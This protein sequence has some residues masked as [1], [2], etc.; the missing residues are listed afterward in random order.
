MCQ[1]VAHLL[2]RG[3]LGM[4]RP[5]QPRTGATRIQGREI[6]TAT[7]T[8][9][10]R[11]SIRRSR[12]LPFAAAGLAVLFLAPALA[13]ADASG[14]DAASATAVATVVPMAVEDEIDALGQSTFPS[15]YGDIAIVNDRTQI[16]VYLTTPTPAIE[17]AFEA[18]APAGMLVFHSTP[19]SLQ[20]LHAL[21]QTVEDQWTQLRDQGIN[22][23]EFGPNI[24][25]G[26]EDVGVENLTDADTEALDSLFGA[27]ALNVY[28][29]TPED[30]NS[31]QV[32]VSRN[33]DVAPYNG[34]D[35]IAHE[36]STAKYLCTSGFGIRISGNPRLLT[37]GHCY[38]VGD[39]VINERCTSFTDCTGGMAAM[40]NVTQ[41]G[42]GDNR[43]N[44]NGQ[45]LD[46]AVFTG[47]NGNGTCGGSDL[48]FTGDLGNPQIATVAGV[49]AWHV[50][51]QVC[52]SGAYG[53]EKCGFEVRQIDYCDTIGKYY[54]CHLTRTLNNNDN[55]VEGDSGAPV[56]LF[57]GSSLYAV[58][59]HTGHDD[60]HH[61]WFTG[62]NRILD[63]WNACLITGS[64]CTT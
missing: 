32:D 48:I 25:I 30:V 46:S 40:G 20:T 52:E 9:L 19:R 15:V 42:L 7:A 26:K 22:V 4:P 57:S 27:D 38:N 13:T 63:V 47:C 18:L 5:H 55:A 24:L 2:I 10:R 50:G 29:V 62:I 33:N 53:G 12:I 31:R 23:V 64:G 14:S 3:G 58:G 45:L 49:G 1:P 8:H 11:R 35:A 28:N 51:D 43:C 44:C 61:E 6:R 41:D 37:A 39:D 17:A 16:A 60:S 21:H 36:T 34:G 54:F 56:F 59:T